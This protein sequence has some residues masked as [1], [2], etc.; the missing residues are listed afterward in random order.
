MDYWPKSQTS[1]QTGW[2]SKME[3]KRNVGTKLHK[4]IFSQCNKAEYEY[5][6]D[7]IFVPLSDLTVGKE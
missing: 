7:N 4:A 6:Y 5:E 2:K 3:S 1:H